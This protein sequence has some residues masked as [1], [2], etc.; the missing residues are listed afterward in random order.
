MGGTSLRVECRPIGGGLGRRCPIEMHPEGE[1]RPALSVP[2]GGAGASVSQG[3]AQRGQRR[4]VAHRRP[5]W[6]EARRD[7]VPAG[8]S[9]Q[10]P[11]RAVS[12]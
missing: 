10:H 1:V 9:V 12:W 3:R 5:G 4:P 6:N 7:G 8:E 11:C 2:E